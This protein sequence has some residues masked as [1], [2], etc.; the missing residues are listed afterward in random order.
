MEHF[1]KLTGAKK[2]IGN[3]PVTLS[4]KLYQ[5]NTDYYISHK[6]DGQRRLLLVTQNGCFFISSKMKF[7]KKD[8]PGTLSGTLSGTLLDGELQ[9]GVFN[10]FDIL[11][12]RNKCL[13]E[14]DLSKRLEFME[15]VIYKLNDPTIILKK[16][17][18]TTK[19]TIYKHVKILKTKYSKELKNG[20]IDGLILTPNDKYYS[21]I[22]KWKPLNLLSIDF[23]IRKKNGVIY[24]LKQDGN[25]FVPVDKTM[26]Y[27]D[28]GTLHVPDDVYL[29]YKNGSILEVI[30]DKKSK[31]FVIHKERPDKLK[32]NYNTVID[33]NFKLMT[34]YE[35]LEKIFTS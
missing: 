3:N 10:V 23:K 31:K 33:S 14:L 8:C 6:L 29:K 20:T 11:Y 24:L 27:Q 19:D 30:F 16:Y 21:Q 25:V 28:I 34:N 13:K 2:F 5:P 35:S 12:Y 9:N 22:L 15:Y 18:K 7:D 32:S 1:K 17:V 26:M 4:K